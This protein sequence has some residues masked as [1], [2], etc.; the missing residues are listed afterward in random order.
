MRHAIFLF[1]LDGTLVLTGGAGMRA[2]ERAFFEVLQIPQ[3]L[4]GIRCDGKTDPAIVREMLRVR[5]IEDETLI[6]RVLDRYLA[7]L[8]HEVA[9]AAGYRV[10]PGVR[11]CL[12]YLAA[13]QTALCGLGTG[14][15]ERG[16]FIKLARADLN[17]FFSFGGYS[18]DSDDR[19]ELVRLALGR[20]RQMLAD[21]DSP[22]LVIGDTPLDI[23]AGK[24]AAALTLG[25]ATGNYSVEALQACGADLALPDLGE[26]ERWLSRLGLTLS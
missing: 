4:E 2:L 25:V 26:P 8:E 5:G 12:E 23:A 19:P 1:D 21:P 9:C 6:P 3:G 20:A 15:L 7:F 11:E 17:R 24:A 13:Q 14:N 18:S 16:A 10:L 22:A